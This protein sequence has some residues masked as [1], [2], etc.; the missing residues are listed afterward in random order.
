MAI[1][2]SDKINMIVRLDTYSPFCISQLWSFI[3]IKL[4]LPR[5][6]MTTK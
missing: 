5:N 6:L 2:E 4:S 1:T 3:V